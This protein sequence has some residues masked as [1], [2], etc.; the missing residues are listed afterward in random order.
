VL[1]LCIGWPYL[2][3]LIKLEI[4]L[5]NF[6]DV[7]FLFGGSKVRKRT[8]SLIAWKIIC[9]SKEQGGLGDMNLKTMNKSLLCK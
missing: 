5:R 8:Y 4:E 7:F 1:Y 6:V 9:Q 2:E 3:F